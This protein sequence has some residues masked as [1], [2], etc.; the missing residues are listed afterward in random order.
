MRRSLFIASRI[1]PL[2]SPPQVVTQFGVSCSLGVPRMIKATSNEIIFLI[3]AD[4]KEIL[5]IHRLQTHKIQGQAAHSIVCF[6]RLANESPFPEVLPKEVGSVLALVAGTDELC[7]ATA[8]HLVLYKGYAK[9][10]T[11]EAAVPTVVQLP[12]AFNFRIG[13]SYFAPS[14]RY[15]SPSSLQVTLQFSL[16]VVM[17]RRLVL[18]DRSNGSVLCSHEHAHPITNSAAGENHV[19]SINANEIII[20]NIADG[21][22]TVIPRSV[23]PTAVA[24]HDGHAVVGDV[25][26]LIPLLSHQLH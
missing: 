7:A 13:T 16:V 9:P 5:Q 1:S 23:S 3:G 20:Q 18:L 25:E 14:N 10:T 15:Y 17:G 6:P 26:G 12:T 21:A 19:V 8:T 4:E 22:A 2:A 24:I 11:S